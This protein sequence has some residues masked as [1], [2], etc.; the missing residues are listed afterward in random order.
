MI[1][2][3]FE[4]SSSNQSWDTDLVKGNPIYQIIMRKFE[5]HYFSKLLK[6]KQLFVYYDYVRYNHYWSMYGF[7]VTY[8]TVKLGDGL[9]LQTWGIQKR[10]G[11][12]DFFF[13]ENII[14]PT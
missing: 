5:E 3:T 6:I 13:V 1:P 7:F 12:S 11:V 4:V 10:K 9:S 8:L 2:S 14:I